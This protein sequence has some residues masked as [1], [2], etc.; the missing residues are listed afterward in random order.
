MADHSKALGSCSDDC[1]GW[2]MDGKLGEVSNSEKIKHCLM[3]N[4]IMMTESTIP[5][6]AIVLNGGFA[7]MACGRDKKERNAFQISPL[8]LIGILSVSGRMRLTCG[9][10]GLIT[11]VRTRPISHTGSPTNTRIGIVENR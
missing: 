10:S 8:F 11:I 5:T 4:W 2:A 6:R 9:A 3:M 1:D 7:K